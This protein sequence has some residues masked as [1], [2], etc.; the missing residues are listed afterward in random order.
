MMRVRTQQAEPQPITLCDFDL[1]QD[2]VCL[3]IDAHRHVQVFLVQL[4]RAGHVDDSVSLLE[5]ALELRLRETAYAFVLLNGPVSPTIAHA[6]PVQQQ[7]E[8][9][10]CGGSG[11]RDEIAPGADWSMLN[12]LCGS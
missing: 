10:E 7:S 12:V 4:R 1:R 9:H 3:D 11:I 8:V 5:R 6:G 2:R